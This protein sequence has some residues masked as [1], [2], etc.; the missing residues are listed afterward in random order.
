MVA[1][2]VLIMLVFIALERGVVKQV[3]QAGEDSPEVVIYTL[4][5]AEQN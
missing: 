4:L 2:F 5:R 3:L 1:L